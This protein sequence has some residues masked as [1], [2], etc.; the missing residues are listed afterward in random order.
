MVADEPRDGIGH[1]SWRRRFVAAIPAKLR[2]WR[3]RRRDLR[4]AGRAANVAASRAETRLLFRLADAVNRAETPEDVYE[5]A[6]EAVLAGLKVER[7]S[8]LLADS[9]KVMRFRAWRGLSDGYRRAVEGHS[10]WS[11]DALDPSPV[12]VEDV[13]VDEAWAAYRELF[14]RERIRSLAFIPLTHRARLI[15]KFMIYSAV[16]RAFSQREVELAHTI[17]AQVSQAVARGGLLLSERIAR[18]DAERSGERMRRLQTVTDRLSDALSTAEVANVVVTQ[19]MAATRAATGGL[20]LV[21]EAHGLLR[22]VESARYGTEGRE[23]YDSIPLGSAVSMPVL[24]VARTGAPVW[25]QSTEELVARYPELAAEVPQP[26]EQAVASLPIRTRGKNTGVL[27]FTFGVAGELDQGQ[28]QFLLTVARQAELAFERAELFEHERQAR[29]EAENAQ[30]R[31]SFKAEASALLASSLDYESTM[32]DLAKL[33]VPRFSD[34]CTVELGDTPSKTT[35]LAAESSQEC[36][37]A[38]AGRNGKPSGAKCMIEA[39]MNV[40]GRPVG[41]LSFGMIE[42]GRCFDQA[43]VEVAMGLGERAAFAI[44]NARLTRDLQRAVVARDDLIAVVSHD[45]RN[46]LGVLSMSA[47]AIVRSLPEGA[48]TEKQRRHG[49][50]IHRTSGR[51]ERLIRDL[52]DMGSIEAGRLN[53]EPHA[54]DVG[55]LLAQAE[56][57]LQPLASARSLR[58]EVEAPPS[59]LTVRADRQR[60]FQVLSNLVGNAIKFTPSGGSIQLRSGRS[61]EWVVFAVRDSGPGIDP[62]HLSRIFDR[63]YQGQSAEPGSMGLG[64][65]IARGIVEAHGGRIWAE[66]APGSGSRFLFTLPVAD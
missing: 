51:M 64:L 7:A 16:P 31:A 57:D 1:G 39:P 50:A 33:A 47:E 44:E 60:V 27:T 9:H 38:A 55:G 58:L 14:R 63:Y 43:D 62:M 20:W 52:L 29:A 4:E 26:A 66:S 35:L 19:G 59:P 32:R 40:H 48:L 10:P 30:R 65:F 6:L 5:P 15:G 11:P 18:R 17:A 12:L 49:E 56:E 61:G 2:K 54:E 21:D 37:R 45:L 46:L 13:E 23:F 53:L 42:P 24:D 28:R 22:L 3:G 25:I 8:V 41:V 34:W 36:G